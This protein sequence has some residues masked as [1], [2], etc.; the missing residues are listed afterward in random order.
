VLS[1]VKNLYLTYGLT[2]VALLVAAHTAFASPELDRQYSLNSVGILKAW[3]NVDGLFGDIVTEVYQVELKSQSRF[4]VQD[5]S[6]ANQLLGTSKIPYNKLI[7]DSEILG[8]LAKSMK[9]DTFLRTKVYK[10]GPEYRFVIDWVHA[11]KLQLIATENFKIVE[12]FS[13]GKSL[14]SDEFRKGIAQALDRLIKKVPFQGMVTGRDQSS[15]TVNLGVQERIKK[16]DTLVIATVDEV[17]FHPLLKTIVDWRMTSTG[18]ATVNEVDDGMAFAKI[19]AEEYGK[20]IARY[21]KIVQVIP[22]QGLKPEVETHVTDYEDRLKASQ[23]PPRLGWISPGLFIGKYSREASTNNGSSGLSGSGTML[24]F[25]ADAQVWFTG[26]WFGEFNYAFGS[27]GYQQK[28][29]ATNANTAATDVTATLNQL[30]MSVGYFYHITPNFFGPKGWAKAGFQSSKYSLPN[31]S[32]ERTSNTSFTSMTIGLGGDLPIRN[33]YGVLLSVDFG[34]FGGGKEAGAYYGTET[35]A[36]AVDVYLGGYT[37]LQPKMKLRVGFD[38]KSQSLDFINGATIS[39]KV[40]AFGPS[41]M[42][43]F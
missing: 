40:L 23:E 35:G 38:F 19:D 4:T 29:I 14:G 32:T 31:S 41:L 22:G 1:S 37:W 9:V 36:S 25:K 12:P 24:G 7:E 13:E 21:Q 2:W 42:F 27:S 10:E 34:L 26:D 15:V 30:R 5:L 43:Y 33:D 39:N 11:P 16:G 17:K 8:Q 3:D 18:R 20:Q 28:D 6:K